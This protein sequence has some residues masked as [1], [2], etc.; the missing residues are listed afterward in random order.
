M[1]YDIIR[2]AISVIFACMKWNSPDYDMYYIFALQTATSTY[3]YFINKTL[4]QNAD[5][6]V[7]SK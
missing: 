6:Q 1:S 4:M 7:P 2:K 3:C 5:L